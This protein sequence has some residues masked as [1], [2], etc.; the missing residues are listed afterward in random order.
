MVA[1][2]KDYEDD[3]M[4]NGLQRKNTSNYSPFELLVGRSSVVKIF[5]VT[6]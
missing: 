1:A 4:C 6:Y 3:I 5:F 2:K